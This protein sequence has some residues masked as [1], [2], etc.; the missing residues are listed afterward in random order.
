MKTALREHLLEKPTSLYEEEMVTFLEE[1]SGVRIARSSVGGLL[2]SMGWCTRRQN[3]PKDIDAFHSIL[4]R[5]L[6]SLTFA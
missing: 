6:S 1:E 5:Q 3:K 4:R 2:H